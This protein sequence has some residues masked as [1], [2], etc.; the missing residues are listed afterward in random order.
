M[1]LV[2]LT[3]VLDKQT[4][5]V[6]ELL[7]IGTIVAPSPAFTG[8]VDVVLG[9]NDLIFCGG[10]CTSPTD[11]SAAVQPAFYPNAAAGSQHF[12]APGAG[13]NINAHFSAKASWDHQT[14]F[15]KMNGF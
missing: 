14:N 1:S 4:T 7:T 3:T 11:Q 9:E 2:F 10:N 5:S 6:G 13:H 8:P 12:L 15:L